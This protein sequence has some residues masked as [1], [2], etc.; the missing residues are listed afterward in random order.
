[1]LITFIQFHQLNDGANVRVLVPKFPEL[2]NTIVAATVIDDRTIQV[3]YP[4]FQVSERGNNAFGGN[5]M[6][7]CYTEKDKTTVL[8][9]GAVVVQADASDASGTITAIQ[10]QCIVVSLNTGSEPF[11]TF[12]KQ[13]S[14]IGGDDRFIH[15]MGNA[16]ECTPLDECFMAVS[17]ATKLM[18]QNLMRLI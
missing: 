7:I 4:N 11:Q 13:I 17:S 10:G 1:M 5:S 6:I 2:K 15:E 8:K 12:Q 18:V 9:I 16:A 14:L 3:K